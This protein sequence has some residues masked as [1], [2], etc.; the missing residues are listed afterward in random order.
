MARFPVLLALSVAGLAPVRA[1]AQITEDVPARRPVA[2]VDLRSDA[3]VR[4]LDA[5]WRYHDADLI[6]VGHRRPG[7]DLKPTGDPNR[8]RDIAPHAGGAGFDDA[9][10]PVVPATSLETRRGEGRFSFG[11]YRITVTIPARIGTLDP[12]GTTAVLEVVV[13]DYAEVWVDGRL[14]VTLGARGGA[15]AAGWNAPNRVVLGHDIQ[16]GQ[17]FEIAIFAGNA[18]LSEP[19]GNY[20]WIRSATLD[21]HRPEEFGNRLPAKLTVTRL[22]PALDSVIG[23]SPT[24][25]KLAGGFTFT[26][27]PVWVGDGLLFSDPND[28]RIYR[29]S[30]DGQVTVFRTKSGY[31]GIDIGEYRQPGSNGLSLDREGRLLIAEHGNRRITRLEKN[32]LLTVLADRYQG[33]RLN[34]PNDLV[35]RSDGSIYF[36]DPPFGLPMVHADPRRELGVTGVY[37]LAPDGTLTQE[38]VDLSG[39]NGI[40]FS[41]DEQYLYV[42]NW[43]PAR[44]VIMRYR[45]APDGSLSGGQVFFDITSRVPG[46]LAWDGVKVD[47][48]GNL[49]AAGPE[50]IYVLASDGRHLGTLGVPEHAANMAWGDADR[51]TLYVTA[52]GGLYRLRLTT[53]GTGAYLADR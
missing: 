34:S 17:R 29:W 46:E 33:R 31:S 44:K 23:P 19:P 49:Y 26:E 14:P 25:E 28:N 51:R 21:F 40:A 16:P 12:T 43:D 9:S 35:P 22:D 2:V 52:T 27:G 41:P 5:A 3:G 20:I 11:W 36:T 47:Q 24:L 39:P 50:G 37:R 1:A 4:L 6:E 8:T 30:P 42:A 18:P 10:W 15:V 48:R 53:T 7:P 38:T 32:G 13:D 45:V